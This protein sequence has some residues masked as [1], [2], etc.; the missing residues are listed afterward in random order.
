MRTSWL[1]T[2]LVHV[3]ENWGF[4][5]YFCLTLPLL[6]DFYRKRART[7]LDQAVE[8]RMQEAQERVPQ[9]ATARHKGHKAERR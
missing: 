3:G 2:V 7:A 6:V 1:E 9:A 4:W 5:L 8:R